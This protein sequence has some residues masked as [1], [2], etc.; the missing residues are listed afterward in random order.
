MYMQ[1]FRN[2]RGGGGYKGGG[3][4]R[5][6]DRPS[7]GGGRDNRGFDKPELHDATCATC[8]NRC[9]VP[10][11][12]NGS[13]PI[14]CRDCFKKEDG[15]NDRGP[16][17][18]DGNQRGGNDRM[19]FGEDKPMFKATCDDCGNG[20][21][22]PFRPTGERPVYCRECF[23]KNGGPT[24]NKSFGAPKSAPTENYGEQI[25]A[26][27]AKMDMVLKALGQTV[28]ATPKAEAKVETKKVEVKAEAKTDPSVKPTQVVAEK[29]KKAPAKK[30]AA[31]KKAK[32]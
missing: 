5:F 15:G 10:F 27:N 26:L 19:S 31:A 2:D 13:K 28:P 18:F 29:A 6:G 9:Q 3:D 21:E 7:F 14:Y 32:K 30:K 22:V 20:C 12:P 17:R 1:N 24:G 4:K 8:G 11:R 16:R 23:G 25:R